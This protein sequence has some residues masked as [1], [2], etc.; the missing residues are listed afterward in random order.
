MLTI[1][2][3]S[4]I[5][6]VSTKTLRY[7]E[8]IGILLPSEVNEANGYRYY[9]LD[10]L[11]TMLFINRLKTYHFSLEEIKEVL[12]A[13]EHDK[14]LYNQL[15]VKKKEINEQIQAYEKKLYQLH[16]DIL[17]LQQGNSIMSYLDN[18]EIK[19]VEVPNMFLVS[20]R[21]KSKALK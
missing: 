12:N 1:G 10:Q 15:L 21:K 11:K 16:Q 14:R 3:F 19:L 9:S 7:Y 13:S 8:E 17:T 5:C 20:V 2:E 4:K 6:K 18:I